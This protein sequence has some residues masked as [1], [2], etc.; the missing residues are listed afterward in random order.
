MSKS[1]KKLCDFALKIS[2]QK[3]NPI[4]STNPSVNLCNFANL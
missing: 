1:F 2:Q 3:V 4:L